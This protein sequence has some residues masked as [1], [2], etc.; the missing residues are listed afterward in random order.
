[1]DLSV[2][3]LS[4][5]NG[6]DEYITYVFGR[7]EGSVGS[8]TGSEENLITVYDLLGRKI[9]ENVEKTSL[10]SLRRGIYIVNGKKVSI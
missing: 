9:L 6:D 7:E 4:V 8:L 1:M 10:S 2:Y 5:G 3:A